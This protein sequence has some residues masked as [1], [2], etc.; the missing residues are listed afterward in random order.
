MTTTRSGHFLREDKELAGV[1]GFE[2]TNAGVRVLCL[3]VWRHP[4]AQSR[5]AQNRGTWAECQGRNWSA[6]V[7]FMI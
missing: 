7:F 5:S 1:V 6:G 2:P 3:A 4:S